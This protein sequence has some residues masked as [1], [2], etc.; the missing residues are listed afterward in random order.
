MALSV[1]PV[2]NSHFSVCQ[3]W[4]RAQKLKL[5]VCMH[6]SPSVRPEKRMLRWQRRALKVEKQVQRVHR[7]WHDNNL[8]ELPAM[9]LYPFSYCTRQTQVLNFPMVFSGIH[10]FPYQIAQR[11]KPEQIQS[12][13][14]QRLQIDLNND[15]LSFHI[16]SQAQYMISVGSWKW[17]F[18]FMQHPVFITI[19]G[20]LDTCV[21]TCMEQYHSP[22][23][24]TTVRCADLFFSLKCELWRRWCKHVTHGLCQCWVLTKGDIWCLSGSTALEYKRDLGPFVPI[25]QCFD[26]IVCNAKY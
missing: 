10:I 19:L 7:L 16:Y 2:S 1:Y 17:H 8:R 6:V 25:K 14:V 21:S 23:F 18:F 15:L 22:I 13:E 11:S 26:L 5:H 20:G 3:L 4:L 12:K 24:C 9:C